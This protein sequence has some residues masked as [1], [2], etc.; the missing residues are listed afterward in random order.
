MLD[1]IMQR[2]RVPG[3]PVQ[4]LELLRVWLEPYLRLWVPLQSK[5]RQSRL[6]Q[7]LLLQ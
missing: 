7:Q 4:Q 2:L 5:L 6:L 1:D 3:K